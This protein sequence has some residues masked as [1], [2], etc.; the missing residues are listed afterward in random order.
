MIKTALNECTIVIHQLFFRVNVD[1]TGT[2][3]SSVS[4]T[5]LKNERMIFS[6]NKLV[7]Y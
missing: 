3:K 5:W 2:R 1:K 4:T 7:T 6:Q